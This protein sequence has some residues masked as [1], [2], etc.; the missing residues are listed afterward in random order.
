MLRLLMACAA[1]ENETLIRTAL[2][3]ASLAQPLT[4]LDTLQRDDRA[5]EAAGMPD[6]TFHD[7]RRSCGTLLIQ[8]GVELHIVSKILG[9]TSTSVT[10]RVYAHLH[11]RQLR[12]GLGTLTVLHQAL[13]RKPATKTKRPRRAAASA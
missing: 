11:A 4:T 3:S 13:H 5:R 6:V 7:L 8:K 10:E 12:A 2:A 9:H 1:P